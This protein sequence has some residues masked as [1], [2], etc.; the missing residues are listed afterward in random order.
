MQSEPNAFVDTVILRTCGTVFDAF[1][2]LNWNSLGRKSTDRGCAVG[3]PA[4]NRFFVEKV[5]TLVRGLPRFLRSSLK[6][7]YLLILV[8]NLHGLPVRQRGGLERL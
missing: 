1:F 3:A 6:K 4:R 7:R 5:Y 8:W 2:L